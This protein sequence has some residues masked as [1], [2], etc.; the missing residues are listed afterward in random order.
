MGKKSKETLQVR[1]QNNNNCPLNS[2]CTLQLIEYTISFVTY[3]NWYVIYK[4]YHCNIDKNYGVH[5][6]TND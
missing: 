2:L 6:K 1:R 3:N 5:R 4:Y